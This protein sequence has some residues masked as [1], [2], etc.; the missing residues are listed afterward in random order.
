MESRKQATNPVQRYI[1]Q[2]IKELGNDYLNKI[3]Q[4]RWDLKLLMDENNYTKFK[5][6]IHTGLYID[7]ID[8][9]LVGRNNISLKTYK[10]IK[11]FVDKKSRKN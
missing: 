11:R 1:N 4:L 7:T 3:E 2:L 9:F 10:L 5:I 6:S 8:D